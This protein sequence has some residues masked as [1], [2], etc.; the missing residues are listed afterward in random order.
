MIKHVAQF[1]DKPGATGTD[2]RE[3]APKRF[4]QCPGVLTASNFVPSFLG[5][6]RGAGRRCARAS[7]GGEK[8]VPPRYPSK[9][10]SSARSRPSA[11]GTG[12]L[13]AALVLGVAGMA[14]D[15]DPRDL[16][17][18]GGRDQ[19]LPEV[20]VLD[21]LLARGL[22]PAAKPPADPVLREGVDHVLRVRRHC[23]RAR[24][25]QSLERGDG[26]HELHAV[27]GGAP[28]AGAELALEGA[29]S[30]PV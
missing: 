1:S 27:V 11:G 16:V 25:A 28:V 6:A 14:L 3:G 20:D 17:W 10:V 15:P 4:R 26:T 24:P 29:P 8:D 13:V 30:G 19:A 12:Q 23:D 18:L 7:A 9:P 5:I 21:G 2:G 22:P